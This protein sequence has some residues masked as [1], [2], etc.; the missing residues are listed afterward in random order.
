VPAVSSLLVVGR[1]AV[2]E[3][4][5]WFGGVRDFGEGFCFTWIR[6]R[7]PQQVIKQSGGKE[8]ERIGWDQLVGSGDG[9]E[10]GAD[11]YFYGVAHVAEWTLMIEDGGTFGTTDSQVGP[12]SRGTTLIS[13]YRGKDG[14]GRL[15]VLDDQSVRLDFDPMAADRI[16]G[17]GAEDLR[18]V[19]DGAGFAAAQRLRTG[20]RNEYRA[21]CTEAAFAL[22][23]RMTGVAM[24]KELLET[25]TYLFTSVPRSSVR[26]S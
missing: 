11:R 4:Y 21:Y 18:P 22:I 8:L 13:H 6:E 25:L 5:R 26:S 10:V 24:T 7:T 23:E 3:D 20:D 12:L 19:I 15:L 9:Q 16:A 14:R 17:S 2:A 1:A